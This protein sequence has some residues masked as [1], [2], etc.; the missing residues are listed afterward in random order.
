MT[1]DR[2]GAKP[3]MKINVTPVVLGKVTYPGGGLRASISQSKKLKTTS[4]SFLFKSHVKFIPD[5]GETIK[6]WKIGFI[7]IVRE[8][9]FRAVYGGRILSEGSVV[10]DPHLSSTTPRVI[11]DNSDPAVI[12]FYALPD[13]VINLTMSPETG[14]SP[15][16]TVPLIVGNDAVKGIDNFLASFENDMEFWTTLTVMEPSKALHFLAHIHWQV[17]FRA[18]VLWRA[19]TPIAPDQSS[20][21]FE[22]MVDGAPTETA[23]SAILSSPTLSSPTTPIA[24]VALVAASNNSFIS[25]AGSDPDTHKASP[26]RDLFSIPQFF[27]E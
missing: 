27:W 22:S 2:A 23:V 20:I 1:V 18:G 21:K 6:N 10:C 7:Q 14:D 19:G 8:N 16:F 25:G 26:E 4:V 15:G 17:I 11:L 24:N 9:S 12:P 13:D 5:S 3:S